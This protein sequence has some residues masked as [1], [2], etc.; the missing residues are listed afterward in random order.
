MKFVK[1]AV[2]IAPFMFASAAVAADHEIQMLNKG[3]DG[4]PMWYEPAILIAEPGDTVTFLPSSKGHNVESMLV[5]EGA[6]EWKSK[7]NK[8]INITVESEGV[9]AYK[10]TPHFGSG[11][12][13]FIVVGDPSVNLEEVKGLRYAGKSKKVAEELIAQIEAGM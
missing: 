10:C 2:A 13:G 7:M 4:Q 6:E 11:M 12:I 3:P 1:A 9:Y 5:P 8:E